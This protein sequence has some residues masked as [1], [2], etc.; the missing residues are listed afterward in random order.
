MTPEQWEKITELFQAAADLPEAEC[1]ALL[2]EKC[3]D[4]PIVRREVESLLAA[5]SEAGD[6]IEEPIVGN[7]DLEETDA[8]LFSSGYMLGRYR[9]D[10]LIGTG[11]MGEVYLALDTTLKR[12][13]ALK[14]LPERCAADPGF[15]RRFR[16]EA[17]ASATLNHPNVATIYTVEEHLGRPFITMEYIEGVTLRELVSPRGISLADFTHWFES[18]ADALAHAHDKGIIHRDVKPGNIIITRRGHPKVLDF[19]LARLGREHGTDE[20]STLREITEPGLVMGTPS[21][22]S[23]EQAEGRVQDHRSD[24]FSLGIVM[25]EALT[26]VRPFKGESYSEMISEIVSSE[27]QP[28]NELR[29]DV[30][31]EIARMITKCLAKDPSKRFSS[32]HEIRAVLKRNQF[33]SRETSTMDSF[34]RRFYRESRSGSGTWVGLAAILVVIISISAWYFFSGTQPGI[35]P[36]NIS[37]SKLSQSNNVVYAHVTPDGR[38]VVYNTIE[39]NEDR[40]MW[41][42]RVDDPTALQLLPPARV[43][44]WGGIAVSADSS[45]VYYITAERSARSGSLFR[46]STLGGQPRKLVDSVNDL[47]SLSPDGERLLLVRYGENTQLISVS[48]QDGGS[49]R[50]ILTAAAGT[51]YRDPQYSID[52]RSIFA[53]KVENIGNAE[54][55]TLVEIPSE[56]GPERVVLPARRQK[57]NEIAV[58]PTGSALLVNQVDAASNL[59]QLFRVRVSDGSETKITNDLNSYFGVSVSADGRSIVTAQRMEEN[60]IY[61]GSTT[62]PE[63]L[64]KATRE[65]TAYIR[66]SWTPDGRLVYG[67]LE[68]NLPQIWLT[69]LDSKQPTRLSSGNSADY[70]PVVSPDGRFVFFV[71]DRTGERKIWRMNIDGSSPSMIGPPDG[72]GI[73]PKVSPDGQKILFTVNRPD[74]RYLGRMPV[75]GG[76]LELEKHYSRSYWDISPDSQLVA[77]V[78]FNESG[79]AAGVAVRSVNADNSDVTILD[80]SPQSVFAWSRDGREIFFRERNLSDDHFS[81]IYAIDIKT[82]TKRMFLSTKPDTVHHLAF[83][84][85]GSRFAVLRGNLLTDAVLLVNTAAK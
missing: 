68:N 31:R 20:R 39:E 25:Y 8:L 72:T 81:T 30:P 19:G 7:I 27:A 16:N 45:Q 36:S 21:Y 40:S 17:L 70:E 80:I 66:S 37:F 71:S 77:F 67:A 43:W 13:V 49:E 15:V 34:V 4:D 33:V 24:I 44:F 12:P 53:S 52:G 1:R 84:N 85:D 75:D 69:A 26:G 82:K 59:N 55:W 47:G 76:K 74:G 65:S 9:I 63:R 64:S 6:F 23:P 58:L 10:R 42:R 2:D 57:I 83:S 38:S 60:D 56:G 78:Q 35:D 73:N 54:T 3:S 61:V 62:N 11:G 46:I 18:I 50:V 41:I 5:G 29:P 79:E 51:I 14:I 32:M 22:M 48:S 28:L